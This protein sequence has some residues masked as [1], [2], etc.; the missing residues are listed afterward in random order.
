[1][2]KKTHCFIEAKRDKKNNLLTRK[3]V[4]TERDKTE[5]VSKFTKKRTENQKVNLGITKKCIFAWNKK[6]TN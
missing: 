3:K 2:P 1:M 5:C 4:N 6:R